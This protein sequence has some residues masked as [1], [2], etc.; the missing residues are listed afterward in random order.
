MEEAE[1]HQVF[2]WA[3]TVI[4]IDSHGDEPRQMIAA[5][6]QRPRFVS[7]SRICEN[8]NLRLA[9]Q[10]LNLVASELDFDIYGPIEDKK[11]WASCQRLVDKS[12]ENV[13]VNY[14][15]LLRSDQ[16]QEAFAQYDGFIFPTLGE[17]FGHVIAESLS[18]GCPVMCSQQTPWT[19][20]LNTGGGVALPGFDAQLWADEIDMRATRSSNQRDNLK[21]AAL[22][23][24]IKWR[25]ELTTTSAVESVLDDLASSTGR[26][27]A[28]DKCSVAVITQG[29]NTAGG[30]QTLTR[31]LVLGLERVGYEVEVF[32]L[33]TS[34]ADP[35]SRRLTVAATWFR[36]TLFAPDPSDP[37]VTHVGANGVEIEP[38]RYIPRIELSRE[39]G[40]FDI[41]QVVAG[42]PALAF[43]AMRSGRPVVLLVATTVA[44]ERAS[45]LAVAGAAMAMWRGGMTRLVTIVE[46]YALRNAD[47]VL[48][49]NQ[50]MREYA[51]SLGQARVF[52]AP[53]GVDTELFAPRA[54][55]WDSARYLLSV[56]RLNDPRK[57]LDRL[58]RSYALMVKKRPSL[59]ALVL[60][61]RGEP[62]AELKKL[63]AELGMADRVH[64]RSD[65][66]QN[67]LPALYRGASVY[68]QA[69]YEEGLG[70]SVI[71]A[72][73]SGLPVVSTDTAGTR[74]TVVHG[75]TGWLVSQGPNVESAIADR[76]ISILDH[77]ASVMCRRARS[78]A[79]EC[80]SHHACLLPFLEV[81]DQL[82]GESTGRNR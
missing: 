46:R 2:P 7:I 77:D 14:R 71:E 39:L 20:A 43:A 18:A 11:Y 40:R 23:A 26:K 34:H 66:S 24:Y 75:D 21:H 56:C 12:P 69:S 1:I 65:Y 51:R 19:R 28:G 9:L 42:G 78:R 48:V 63:V 53:P 41:V 25:N 16:V 27:Q 49:L 55:G 10:A 45:Q 81:Y 57:G 68:L 38:M 72:M 22:G 31:W 36:R 59:P 54:E 17:N 29:C 4:Q 30:V 35:Y 6:Q 3:R 79:V 13:R 80:Y 76:T 33:A 47:V 67:N 8:K 32:D 70:I 62:P 60:A 50:A 74:E 82:L 37:Q 58:V 44:W 61:G 15:G 5:S 52:I 73:A 64:I